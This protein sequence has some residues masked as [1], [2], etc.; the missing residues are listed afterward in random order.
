MF[1]PEFEVE[2]V[3]EGAILPN[4]TNSLLKHLLDTNP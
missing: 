1:V 3:E 2:S 4:D